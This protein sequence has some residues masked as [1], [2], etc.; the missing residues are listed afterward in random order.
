MTGAEDCSIP[1]RDDGDVDAEPKQKAVSVAQLQQKLTTFED[2]SQFSEKRQLVAPQGFE[3][4]FY[5]PEP[6][7]LPLDQGAT[8]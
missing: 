5:G 8:M 6:H 4:R 7:V 3:P 1:C 2:R